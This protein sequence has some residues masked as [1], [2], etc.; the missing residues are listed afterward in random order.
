MAKDEDGETA[1]KGGKRRRATKR[2]LAK[3]DLRLLEQLAAGA[4]IEEI[5]GEPGDIAAT[6]AETQ[7]GYPR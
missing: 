5:A 2:E 1:D 7:G 3:R 6:R 4:T